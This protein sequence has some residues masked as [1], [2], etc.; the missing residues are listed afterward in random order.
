VFDVVHD[1][2]M[3]T[4]LYAS[5]EKFVL[6]DQSYNEINGAPHARG[7]DKIDAFFFQD[8]GPP[9]YA[10]TMNEHFL[11]DMAVR[12]FNYVFIHFRDPDAMGHVFRF[13]GSTY[14]QEVQIVDAY[15]GDVLRIVETDPTLKGKTTIILNTDHGGT[16]FSHINPLLRE[17]Y[18]IPIFVWG[19]GVGRGDLYE[20]N[21]QSRTDPGDSRPDY[22]AAGQPIRNGDTANLA[23]KLLGLGPIPSSSIN[24]KQ[25]LRVSQSNPLTP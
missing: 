5:K 21:Q 8:D 1:A 17:N 10:A 19:A 25:D 4:A 24:A 13:G 18:T 20:M 16:G 6:F 15:L 23:L 2:G 11:A 22:T 7:R 12:H 14:R 3:S 9:K